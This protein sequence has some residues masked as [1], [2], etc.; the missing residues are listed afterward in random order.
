[1]VSPDQRLQRP[2]YLGGGSTRI[3]IHPI[4]RTTSQVAA[5]NNPPVA[6][7]GGF[8]IAEGS[9]GFVKSFTEHGV[10]LGLVNVRADLTYQ[11]GIER[12][13]S[14]RR[15]YDFYWP[16]LAHLGS[17]LFSTERFTGRL[18]RP[19]MMCLVTRSDGLSIATSL[20]GRLV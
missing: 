11:Q 12:M 18:R 8:A 7:L 19:T 20:R 2:E 15:R 5:S 10:I 9:S 3:N 17:R 1:M 14:R 16:A 4:A 6:A 13:F